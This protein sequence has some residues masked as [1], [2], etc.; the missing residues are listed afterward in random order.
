[1][2]HSVIRQFFADKHGR[3]VIF[4]W[5]NVPIIIWFLA[6]IAARVTSGTASKTARALA[7]ASLLV[8]AVLEVFYGASYFRRVLGLLVLAFT[9]YAL[10]W[11]D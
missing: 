6:N 5:P 11:Y 9:L 7:T 3:I 4:Q 10:I 8:W 1:M 2:K